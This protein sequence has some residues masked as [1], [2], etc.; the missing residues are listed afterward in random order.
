VR[1]ERS[2]S[3]GRSRARSDSASFGDAIGREARASQPYIEQFFVGR[4]D[5]MT[6]DDFERCLYLVRRRT[7]GGPMS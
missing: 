5:G 3:V 6:E 1:V 4:P 7:Q 2:Q